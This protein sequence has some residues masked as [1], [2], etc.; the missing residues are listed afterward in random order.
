MSAL[1][2]ISVRGPLTLGALAEVEGVAPPTVTKIVTKLQQQGLVE[3]V[4]D[5]GDRRVARVSIT[6]SGDDLLAESR[7]RKTEWLARRLSTLES[8]DL[9]VLARSAEL[10]DELLSPGGDGDPGASSPAGE[11]S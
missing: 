11:S 1:A 8:E 6:R 7:E 4:V 5:P 9:E 3:R 2:V 10:I